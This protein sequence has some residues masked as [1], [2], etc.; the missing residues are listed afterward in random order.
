[1]IVDQD[2]SVLLVAEGRFRDCADGEIR[3]TATGARFV[4]GLSAGSE[5]EVDETVAEAIAAAGKPWPILE[6]RPVCSGSLQ[7]LD[8]HVWQL[9]C[10]RQRQPGTA[11]LVNPAP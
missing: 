5:Q 10:P 9:T 6:E 4:T 2:I 3:Q 7:D 8:G 11:A 1:M